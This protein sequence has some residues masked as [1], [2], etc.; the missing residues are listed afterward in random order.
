MMPDYEEQYSDGE[1]DDR[2]EIVDIDNVW[3]SGG[4][5]P[6]SIYRDRR[7]NEEKAK[8]KAEKADIKRALKSTKQRAKGK[9][10][11]MDIDQDMDMVKDEPISPEKRPARLPPSTEG[12]AVRAFAMVGGNEEMQVDEVDAEEEEEEEVNKAQAVDLSES[13][14]EEEEEGMEGDFVEIEGGVS[15]Q[16]PLFFS[17]CHDRFGEVGL[18][19]QEAPDQK[20]FMFQFPQF[21]PKFD[22]RPI[23]A[24]NLKSEVN[25]SSDVKPD[26]KPDIKPNVDIKPDIR[27]GAPGSRTRKAQPPP[28]GQIGTMVVMKS[29]KVK[30]ILG[31]DI[32]MNVSR[33]L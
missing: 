14:S 21:F 28:E 4:T 2:K 9:K 22:P 11:D 5:A 16:V 17:Q 3:R 32:V 10:R 18:M 6:T 23:D 26:T 27:P 8:A 15:L 30:M 31:K 1:D 20:L 33:H 7:T 29:G 24:T 25:A 13:E 19:E 12:G